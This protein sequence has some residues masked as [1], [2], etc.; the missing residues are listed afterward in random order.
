MDEVT[1]KHFE[2]GMLVALL[3]A[4]PE[5]RARAFIA[6]LRNDSSLT[7]EQI[8]T[9]EATLLEAVKRPS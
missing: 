2:Q 6:G 5:E 4:E 8:A 7:A 9:L 1:Q 3:D